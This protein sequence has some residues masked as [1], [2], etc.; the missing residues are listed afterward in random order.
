MTLGNFVLHVFTV[1]MDLH[2]IPQKPHTQER[3]GFFLPE[4]V[5]NIG[6]A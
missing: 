2:W 1:A 5:S 4:E 3:I 6:F